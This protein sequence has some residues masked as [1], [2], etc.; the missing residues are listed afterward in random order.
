[1]QFQLGPNDLVGVAMGDQGQPPGL[2]LSRSV[3]GL[4]Q[5]QRGHLARGVFGQACYVD[6]KAETIIV[7]FASGPNAGNT[8]IDPTSPPAYQS[9]ADHL[10]MTVPEA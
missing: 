3:V 1:M 4:A 9:I 7:R 10:M 6:P 2:A 8:V 5:S